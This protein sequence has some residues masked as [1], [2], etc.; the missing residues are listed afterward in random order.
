MASPKPTD[1]LRWATNVGALVATSAQYAT[2][3]GTGYAPTNNPP[4][5]IE[6]YRFRTQGEWNAFISERFFVTG[7]TNENFIVRS[8][9]NEVGSLTVTTAN[10]TGPTAGSVRIASGTSSS[11][12]GSILIQPQLDSE[13][14]SAAFVGGDV[15]ISGG[16]N[17]TTSG[18]AGNVTIT[19]LATSTGT[20]GNVTITGGQVTIQEN[21][22]PRVLLR[23]RSVSFINSHVTFVGATPVVITCTLSEFTYLGV[24]ARP[25]SIGHPV[26]LSTSNGTG[27]NAIDRIVFPMTSEITQL[28]R[29]QYFGIAQNN[30]LP[31]ES[32]EV[33][34]IGV[35]LAHA[36]QE[37]GGSLSNALIGD[38]VSPN[39]SPGI[40]STP[41]MV[42]EPSISRATVGRVIGK[43][44]ADLAYV[45]LTKSLVAVE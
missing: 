3:S 43:A 6:N 32:V 19:S 42:A 28:K 20:S 40:S 35:A 7:P 23:S 12:G 44:T 5:S 18:T 13:V 17:G 9:L 36:A 21:G 26:V 33:A 25:V 41:H 4:A 16:S 8:P 15:T 29:Y 39:Q 27:T 31:G 30:A 1:T 34:I 38:F 2:L 45:L 24:S 14:P 11:K 37:F 10:T 22:N